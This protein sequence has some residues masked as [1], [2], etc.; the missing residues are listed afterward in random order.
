MKARVRDTSLKLDYFTYG[1]VRSERSCTLWCISVT[2]LLFIN[3]V[4]GFGVELISCVSESCT[5]TVENHRK[6]WSSS[7][8]QRCFSS[9][10]VED[11]ESQLILSTLE[12]WKGFMKSVTIVDMHERIQLCSDPTNTDI[13]DFV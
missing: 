12:L 13:Y 6:R 9:A 7:P 8:S 4:R 3:P 11:S 10:S 5:D 1:L 2:V